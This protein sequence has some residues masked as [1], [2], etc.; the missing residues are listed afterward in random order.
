MLVLSTIR[1]LLRV[2]L[3]WAYLHSGDDY[4]VTKLIIPSS[5]IGRDGDITTKTLTGPPRLEH[6]RSCDCI[7]ADFVKLQ[8]FEKA[9]CN[10]SLSLIGFQGL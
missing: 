2:R 4:H 3:R 10:N 8:R 5:A 1:G 6:L 7:A 9:V